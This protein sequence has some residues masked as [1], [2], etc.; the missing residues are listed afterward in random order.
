MGQSPAFT[1]V[2][3]VFFTPKLIGQYGAQSDFPVKY[4]VTVR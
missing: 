1:M 4:S 2:P 3:L